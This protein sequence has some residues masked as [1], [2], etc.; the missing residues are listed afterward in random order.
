MA[1]QAQTA[2]DKGNSAF[3][4]GDYATAIGHYT[5][6][7]LADKNDPTFFL[8]RA[9]AY[10]KLGK[11]EDAERD[12]TSTLAI[13]PQNVKALFRRGQARQG[14]GKV[15]EA[16]KDFK[17]ALRKEPNND[18]VQQELAKIEKGTKGG[19]QVRHENIAICSSAHSSPV[20]TPPRRRV[21][22]EIIDDGPPRTSRSGSND[23][24]KSSS[25]TL[26]TPAQGTSS[27][28]EAKQTRDASK[29]SKVGGGLFRVDGN[30]SRITPRTRFPLPEED[31]E[32]SSQPSIAV[33]TPTTSLYLSTRPTSLHEFTRAWL[34]TNNSEQRW[35]YLTKFVEPDSLPQLFQSNLEPPILLSAF[36]TFLDVL[37]TNPQATPEVLAYMQGLAR[38][39]RINMVLL[40][41]SDKERDVVR[42]LCDRLGD[43]ARVRPW[44]S[45][46]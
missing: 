29:Q 2:K 11:L 23:T 38:V 44:K 1:S 41:L 20:W 9:A 22:I 12:C 10:L 3:K 21:P 36:Q 7:I 15:D 43:V 42:R 14:V 30:H 46:L 39:S 4:S 34:S 32:P 26:A 28:Q 25:A 5:E 16:I 17:A 6:A 13:D 45:V 33:N 8:N 24:P 31:E 19:T 40:F 18:A 35:Q 27:F 37:D